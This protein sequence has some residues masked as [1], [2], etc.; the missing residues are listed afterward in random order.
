MRA[1]RFFR[2]L[3]RVNAVLIAI[4]AAGVAVAVVMAAVYMIQDNVRRREA[5]ASAVIPGK[6]QN[7]ELTLSGLTTIEG[8]SLFR[9]SLSSQ[10]YRGVD[11]G[12]SGGSASDTRNVL[13]IDIANG[14]A[15]W[16]LPN[17]NEVVTSTY[18]VIDE[19]APGER[20]APLGIVALV[21]PNADDNATGR[22]L[23]LR[24]AGLHATPFASDVRALDGVT[25]APSGDVAV[26]FEK[27]R[28]YYLTLFD[29]ATLTKR[30]EREITVPNLR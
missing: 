18:D 2:G 4:A 17:D 1:Q 29:K 12:S 16:L 27:N 23:M 6:P 22:L 10:P 9:A 13:F 14:T 28:K 15:T 11:L 21:K 24:L 7:K 19:P 5:A 3:W 25:I 26:L 20:R 8:T 30:S